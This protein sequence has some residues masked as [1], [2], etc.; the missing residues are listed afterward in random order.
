MEAEVKVSEKAEAEVTEQ[1]E[2]AE[3]SEQASHDIERWAARK[4]R[5][6]ARIARWDL[7]VAVFLFVV[8]IIVIILLFQNVGIEIVAPVAIFGLVMVW[9][10][11]WRRGRQLYAGFYEEELAKLMRELSAMEEREK[12]KK[13]MEGR[14]LEETIEETV[15]RA[16]RERWR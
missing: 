5:E 9:L 15:Q 12:K 2:E 11:G 7:D 10:M 4:A 1:V 3:V 6:R 14:T 8:L 16:L 13:K